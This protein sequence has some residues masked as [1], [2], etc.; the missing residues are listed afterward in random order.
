VTDEIRGMKKSLTGSSKTQNFSLRDAVA[1]LCRRRWL[2]LATLF[3]AV[4]ATT[5]FA[6]L[7][8]DKY[9][10]R[11]KLLVKNMR[12]DAPVTVGN[13]S[14]VDRAEVSESQIV[15]AIEMLKSRDLLEEVIKRTNLARSAASG[16]AATDKDIEKALF[17]LEKELQ[18]TP[19]KKANIIEIS[20]SSYSPETSASVLKVLSELFLEKHLKMHR[21]PGTS[22]FFKNQAGQYQQELKKAENDFSKFQ[23]Q[24]GVVAINQQKELTVSKLAEA[25]SKLKDL[26]GTIQ[27]T[28]KRITTL[29]SQL[30]GMERRVTTQSRVLPNQYSVERLN[31]MLVELRNKRIQLLA[32]FQPTD[33]VVKEVDEQIEETTGALEKAKRSTAVE[34]SSDLNPQRQSLETE[35]TR[36][37]VEQSGRIALHKNLSEQVQM[38]QERLTKLEGATATHDELSRQVKQSEENYQL[39]ARKQEE[40][41]IEDALDEKKITNVTVAEA[42]IV[43]LTPNRAS[44]VMVVVVGLLV[45]VLLAFG[46][47]FVSELTRETVLTPRELQAFTD[48]PVLATIPLQSLK[49]EESN[50]QYSLESADESDFGFKKNRQEDIFVKNIFRER[51]QIQYQED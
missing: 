1:G 22:E 43:P 38:Y 14:V 27:E 3:T 31:T 28:D 18:I 9:E 44:R 47:A 35:L 6:S 21:M 36:A 5:I 29:E 37:K 12:T 11:M 39:Y 8:P 46:G 51:V 19:I 30:S 34:Q 25:T 2:I 13:E 24:K 49:E 7:T 16:P 40:S 42:P 45:G 10:S 41:R 26:E 33:R 20:Y 23:Q 17:K 4:I 15:S 48:V 32:K 50:F